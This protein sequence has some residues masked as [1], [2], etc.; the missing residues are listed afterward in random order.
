MTV[1]TVPGQAAAFLPDNS[2]HTERIR[3]FPDPEP[4]PAGR[5]THPARQA[6][7]RHA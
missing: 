3:C 1:V 5:G 7:I 2:G 6:S 4:V